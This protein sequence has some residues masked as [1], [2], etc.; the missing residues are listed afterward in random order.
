MTEAK[1]FYYNTTLTTFMKDNPS[2][3]WK[4]ILPSSHDSTAFIINDQTCTDPVVI[5]EG[6]NRYF[7]SVFSQ[8]DGSRPPF[9][10]NS[11][12]ALPGLELT[13]AGVFNLL[14]K[15]DTTKSTGPDAI[16]NMFLKRY[17]EWDAHYLTVIFNKSLDTSTVPKA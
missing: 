5:S 17:S 1:N 12:H 9:I 4:T 14:L 3:F 2:K 7:H 6:I 10:H 15:V 13:R 16:P 11:E 8:D